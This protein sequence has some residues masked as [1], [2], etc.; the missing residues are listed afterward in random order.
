MSWESIVVSLASVV[1]IKESF[2]YSR[3]EIRKGQY[4]VRKKSGR[5]V[6]G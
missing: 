3:F 4:Y 6:L 2:A 5:H 1:C